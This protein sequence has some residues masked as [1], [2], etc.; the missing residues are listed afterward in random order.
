MTQEIGAIAR[1]M[2]LVEGCS[3]WADVTRWPPGPENMARV[4]IIEG[5]F[6]DREWIEE[7]HAD[8]ETAERRSNELWAERRSNVIPPDH[9]IQGLAK[10]AVVEH[11]LIEKGNHD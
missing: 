9:W 8:R 11:V 2:A 7:V 1:A 4:Y 3:Y 10:Y 6:G 5:W